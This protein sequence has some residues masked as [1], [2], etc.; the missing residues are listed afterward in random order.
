MAV[1]SGAK[2]QLRTYWKKHHAFPS[3][4]NLCEVV[5]MSST[6]SVFELVNR[7]KDEGYLERIEHLMKAPAVHA[8]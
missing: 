8:E 3:M 4:A 2:E 5:G 7:L 1:T 6:A